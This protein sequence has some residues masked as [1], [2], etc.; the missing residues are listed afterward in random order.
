M[1][2]RLTRRTLLGSAL[3]APAV[4]TDLR[5]ATLRFVPHQ[6]LGWL[7]PSWWPFIETRTHSWMV[8]D[9]LYGLDAQGRAQPQMAEGHVKEDD[10]RTW[11]IRLR[12]GWCSTTASRSAPRIAWP[13]SPAGA[14]M[15]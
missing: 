4:A 12:E 13:A 5:P 7:D 9:T 6:G 14:P 11:R 1:T 3:A 15:R 8:Y 10:G 2:P